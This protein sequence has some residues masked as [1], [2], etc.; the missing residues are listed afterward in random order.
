SFIS[1]NAQNFITLN[2]QTDLEE[3]GLLVK[4]EGFGKMSTKYYFIY[5]LDP[6]GRYS[7]NSTSNDE[8]LPYY[9]IR[10][11]PIFFET[12][13]L[14]ISAFANLS[15]PHGFLFLQVSNGSKR[16]FISYVLEEIFVSEGDVDSPVILKHDFENSMFY[17]YTGKLGIGPGYYSIE[18]LDPEES[19]IFSVIPEYFNIAGQVSFTNKTESV[20]KEVTFLAQNKNMI[21]FEDDIER[22]E[23]RMG[24]DASSD[25]YKE[26]NSFEIIVNKVYKNDEAS[27]STVID[28][29]K[30]DTNE[31][32]LVFDNENDYVLTNLDPNYKYELEIYLEYSILQ[33]RISIFPNEKGRLHIEFIGDDNINIIL[34]DVDDLK[35]VI[36]LEK[37]LLE[38]QGVGKI[39]FH[40]AT[41]WI[42]AIGDIA[43][44][45]LKKSIIKGT[46]ESP[47]DF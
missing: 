3:D 29:E 45:R 19:Y 17:S 16:N 18:D 41:T 10:S 5:N 11:L 42:D 32:F 47:A 1:L 6:K 21:A 34:N 31:Y 44:L 12:S 35:N 15:F 25:N 38:K 27:D 8:S 26:G 39:I 33:E 36:R 7:F 37:Q 24:E 4:S 28:T 43:L 40:Y 14:H 30:S 23:L 46:A 13:G 20:E 22:L 2:A 9:E